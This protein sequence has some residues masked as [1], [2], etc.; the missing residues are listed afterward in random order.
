MF[1]VHFLKTKQSHFERL[2]RGATIKGITREVLAS[3]RVPL[4]PLDEQRRIAAILDK[5]EALRAA[6]STT[7]AIH[8]S[9]PQAIFYENSAN[10]VA[11]LLDTLK[12]PRADLIGYS[13][14]GAVTTGA[15]N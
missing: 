7:L 5:A 2:A 13:M 6:R 3:L 14:S 1:D 11:A 4:P 10:D 8:D 9:L 15:I 12:I